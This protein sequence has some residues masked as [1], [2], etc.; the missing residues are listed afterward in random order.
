MSN[1]AHHG[2]TGSS[3]QC[4]NF[5]TQRFSFNPFGR[6][7]M[8]CQFVVTSTKLVYYYFLIDS[9]FF[10]FYFI[11]HVAKKMCFS[12][13]L[14]GCFLCFW[15]EHQFCLHRR[16][17]MIDVGFCIHVLFTN[18]FL[19]NGIEKSNNMVEILRSKIEH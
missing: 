13:H 6:Y 17:V 9:I 12:N 2:M 11:Y 10:P 3:F 1:K 14:W 5:K 18:R 15:F 19:I 4:E 16:I 7:S 8:F